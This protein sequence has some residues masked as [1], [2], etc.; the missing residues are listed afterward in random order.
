MN[1]IGTL[2]EKPIHSQLKYFFEKD[3]RFHEIK[4]GKYIADICVENKIIEIQ[5]SQLSRLEKKLAF[6]LENSYNVT[7]IYP[8]TSVNILNWCDLTGEIVSSR[9]C[10]KKYAVNNILHELSG[11]TQFIDNPLLTIKVNFLLCEEVRMLDGYGKDK[12]NRPTKVAKVVDCILDEFVI[13][14]KYDL[15]KLLPAELESFTASSFSK[16]VGLKARKLYSAIKVLEALGLIEKAGKNK[17][18]QIW[19]VAR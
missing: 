15:F 9:R 8:V 13:K 5:T 12:K 19:N 10:T 7:V 2:S 16:L 1:K 6:Y 11:I 4:V 18:A 17:R 14:D 3:A